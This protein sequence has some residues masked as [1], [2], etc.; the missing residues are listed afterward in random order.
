MPSQNQEIEDCFQEILGAVLDLG[1]ASGLSLPQ[2]ARMYAAEE[3]KRIMITP[4]HVNQVKVLDQ[5]G[6]QQG[7]ARMM[8]DVELDHLVEKLP[9]GWYAEPI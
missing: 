4:E 9:D 2:M 6:N 5:N 8:T 7:E 3:V 1:R